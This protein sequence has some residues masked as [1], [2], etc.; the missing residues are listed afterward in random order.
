MDM[1]TQT[2][3]LLNSTPDQGRAAPEFS[4]EDRSQGKELTWL[5][6]KLQYTRMLALTWAWQQGPRLRELGLGNADHKILMSL[7]AHTNFSGDTGK[8]HPTL[9]R[10]AAQTGYTEFWIGKRI[11][12][13]ER[14]GVIGKEKSGNR[15]Y[16]TL[17]PEVNGHVWTAG[18]NLEEE[19]RNQKEWEQADTAKNPNSVGVE[20][21]LSWA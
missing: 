20:P 3:S 16:Y 8:S 9:K 10:I 2:A 5:G 19:E 21:Q 12:V 18:Q 7:A 15:N 6:V 1:D 4:E 13:M 11:S 14:M 17:R